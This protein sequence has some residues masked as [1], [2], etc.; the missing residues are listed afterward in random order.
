M[1]L[2]A[3]ARRF[4]RAWL[5][6]CLFITLWILLGPVLRAGDGAA[7]L[8]AFCATPL[9]IHVYRCRARPRCAR[10]ITTRRRPIHHGLPRLVRRQHSGGF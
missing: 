7:A 9:V 10:S 5:T 4:K 6:M 1:K 3:I 8:G 2:R